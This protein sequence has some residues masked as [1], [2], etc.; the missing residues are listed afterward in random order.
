[1]PSTQMMRRLARI[2][3]SA[4]LLWTGNAIAQSDE[5]SLRERELEQ[6]VREL[7][8]RVAE[9]EKR[10]ESLAPLKSA[11]EIESGETD[12]EAVG[13]TGEVTPEEFASLREKVQKLTAPTSFRAYWNDGLRLD[14]FDGSFKL[15]IGGR[16]HFDWAFYA[17]DGDIEGTVGSLDDG[18][19]F[20]RARIYMS[21]QI[22]DNVDFKVE[23]DFAGGDSDFTDVYMG[24]SDLPVVGNIRIGH[25]KE[26]FS[27][28]K[29]TSG[30]D[31]TF[32]ERGLHTV[33]SPVRNSGIMVFDTMLEDRL[34][35]AVGFFR[36]TDDFGDGS[37]GR[38]Y[39]VT[40]RITGVPWYEDQG[41]KLLH[42]GLAYSHQN[43]EDDMV[44]FRERPE[45][46]QAPRFVDTMNFPAEYGDFLGGEI[47]FVYGPFS[48]QGEYIQAWVESRRG[49]DP[50]FW[51]TSVQAGYVLTGEHRSYNLKNAA[52]AEIKPRRPYGNDGGWGAWEVAARYSH[53]D[54]NNA[55]IK[56]GELRDLTFGLNW[57]LN[58]NMRIM[59]NYVRADLVR[60]GDANIYQMRFQIA[61]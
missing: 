1:M 51:G 14:S 46:H 22:Y 41:R 50:A 16:I 48:L 54:L 19:E 38:D 40:T 36:D 5:P 47:A 12:C 42:L 17:A 2:G 56:G 35:W 4:A 8:L 18:T 45:S 43:Y 15:R 49:P 11:T 61:F 39:N 58:N 21:G 6:L 59:W 34:S 26:P 7:S 33:F 29:M 55:N 20:R 37:I 9:L 60:G 24:V 28:E 32:Q 13:P 30:N 27:L 25:F 57:Y 3:L 52:F 23:Y 53:L 31:L 44:R 10:V